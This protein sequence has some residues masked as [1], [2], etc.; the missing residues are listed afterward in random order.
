MIY[1]LEVLRRGVASV[2]ANILTIEEALV[3]EREK[4]AEYEREIAKAEA[5][6]ELHGKG[7]AGGGP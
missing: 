1:D 7:K 5:I 6:L 3:R 4:L 2:R